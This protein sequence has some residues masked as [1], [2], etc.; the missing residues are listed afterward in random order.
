MRS[1]RPAGGSRP[2]RA[3]CLWG[4]GVLTAEK[5]GSGRVLQPDNRQV[6]PVGLEVQ[7][8]FDPDAAGAANLCLGRSTGALPGPLGP[9]L[10]PGLRVGRLAAEVDLVWGPAAEGLMRP[11]L[12]EPG[13]VELKLG[14]HLLD[15]H[16]HEGQAANALGL[17]GPDEALDD[18]DGAVLANG[19]EAGLD[20]EALAPGLE[21]VAEELRPLVEDGVPGLLAGLEEESR[22][23]LAI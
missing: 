14:E 6:S 21:G 5:L 8:E 12:V 10:K 13:S 9:G 4:R 2:P 11:M 7:H 17:E 20:L 18:G 15:V 1:H 19:A 22:V 23:Q 3:E 16:G